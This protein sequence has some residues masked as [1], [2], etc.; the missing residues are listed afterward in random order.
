MAIIKCLQND[1]AE[2]GAADKRVFLSCLE[3]VKDRSRRF[4]INI[5][6]QGRRLVTYSLVDWFPIVRN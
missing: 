6:E 4:L 1:C 3:E 2:S 5:V